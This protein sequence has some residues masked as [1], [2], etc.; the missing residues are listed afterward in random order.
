MRPRSTTN[1]PPQII[2]SQTELRSLCE[3]LIAAGYFAFD[4]EFVGEDKHRPELCLIQVAAE[5]HCY[6]ID[7]L[8]GVDVTPFW[9]LV[10]DER[11]ETIVHAG[12]EDLAL[13]WHHLGR[14]PARVLDLQIAGGFVGLG[15]PSSLARLAAQSIGIR[16][17]KSQTLTDWRRRPL[18]AEQLQYAS[19]DVI[20]LPAMH[21]WIMRRLAEAG[22]VSW[23]R[24]ECE[25]AGR[26]ALAAARGENKLSRLR[27]AGALRGQELAIAEALLAERDRL[28]AEY[29]RPARTVLRDHI[30]VELARR[31]W[32]DTAKIRTL[33]GLNLSATAARR[34]AE[35]IRA[36]Q[37]T[38]KTA[39][40]R[41]T[42]EQDSPEEEVLIAIA[43]AVLRD[44]SNQSGIA[45]ALLTGRQDLRELVRSYTRPPQAGEA[46]ICLRT[47]WRRQAIGDLLER[48]LAGEATIRI[49]RDRG[50]RQLDIGS[51]P[52][53]RN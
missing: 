38:P 18:N 42:I 27:G 7:P 35:A 3:R 11:I 40:P 37:Q 19:E 41:L 51:W 15:Y 13:C 28:A 53:V 22:R 5:D 8:A 49:S 43:S 14:P 12:S 29:N 26:A 30:L 20:H 34:L 52:P 1:P 31:G 45:Y 39:W 44:F 17:H 10:A 48:I 46:E 32:T 16:L 25:S 50:S 23:A 36:G 9:E 6:L 47:G 33:R 21:Q 24:E 4:T 2:V